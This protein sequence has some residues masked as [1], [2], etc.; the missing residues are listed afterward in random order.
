V[1]LQVRLEALAA[2]IG[3]DI[4]DLIDPIEAGRGWFV[5][6]PG[7]T[8]LDSFGCTAVTA[9]GTATAASQTITNKYTRLRRLEYLVTT[10]AT[11]AVAGWRIT[12]NH[13]LRGNSVGVGG[14]YSK[15]IWGPATGV[16]TS[17]TRAFVGLAS[18]TSAPTDVQPSTSLASCVGMGWDSADNNIQIMHSDSSAG[19]TKVDLGASF[20]VPTVDHTSVYQLEIWCSPNDTKYYWKVTD[21]V[22]GVTA[23]GDTGVSTDIPTN[24]IYLTERGWMS[25]G[26][27]SSVIGIALFGGYFKVEGW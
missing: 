6:K 9:T 21:I 18:S 25:V 7:A 15:Q 14:F 19:C 5:P 20:P 17:T 4:K 23:S 11:T 10:A 26:G 8:T 22:S 16:A 3:A 27:T 1:S 24:T 13:L 12:S 2:A